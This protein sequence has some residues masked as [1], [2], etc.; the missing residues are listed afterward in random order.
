MFKNTLVL[1]LGLIIGSASTYFG[2]KYLNKY[3]PKNNSINK[4]LS[5]LGLNRNKVIGFLPYWLVG[6]M[7]K[8]YTKYLTTLTYYGLTVGPDGKIQKETNPG[9]SEP[10][11]FTLKS[12]KMDEIFRDARK[13]N[14]SLS[15]L[16]FSSNEEDIGN[17]INDPITNAKTLV[18]EVAPYM[19]QHNF[20]DLNLDIESVIE[21]SESARQN[22]TTFIA[23][24][25]KNMDRQ[26]LGTLTID[27]SPIV[28]FKKYLI[29]LTDIDKYVDNIV[30]MT[31]DFHYPGSSV[32]GPVSPIS[33]AG[34][35]AELDSEVSI[36]EALKNI[37]SE[38]IIL[39]LPLY[40]YSW[41]TLNDT[42]RSAVIPGTG[43]AIS[44]RKVEK[45]LESCA[46]CSAKLDNSALESYVIYKDQETGTYHQ[47]FYPDR[48][49]TYKKIQL[50]NKY[51]IGGMALW[52]LGYDG[53]NI[54]DPLKDYKD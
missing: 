28:L 25:K 46:T 32:T 51:K 52:A 35:D 42:P 30:L 21:A 34:I 5:P 47:I 45:F 26:N 37:S 9:E 23:E 3:I 15:L 53:K 14:L 33:G 50:T 44:N 19:K 31:Y 20:D 2:L 48:E 54:L 22:F 38:K 1:I 43:L 7:D 18:S 16:I 41:E 27:A 12:G 49:A 17:L 39:G 4:I 13:N 36:V 6:S 11:I 10:G 8:D 24:V 29:N 40:G